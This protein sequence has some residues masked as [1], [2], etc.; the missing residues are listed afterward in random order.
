M[1]WVYKIL[2]LRKGFGIQCTVYKFMRFMYW[3]NF[4]SEV[5]S[6]EVQLLIADIAGSKAHPVLLWNVWFSTG[7]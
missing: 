3:V 5:S 6:S 4:P 1:E 2:D 7:L